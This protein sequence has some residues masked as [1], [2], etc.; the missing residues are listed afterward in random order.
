MLNIVV[1]LT[2]LLP[3]G[4]NGGAKIMALQL[5]KRMGRIAPNHQFILLANR[6]NAAE[7]SKLN[8]TNIK[9]LKI[10]ALDLTFANF[11]AG[12]VYAFFF[13]FIRFAKAFMPF[14]VAIRVER[15]AQ[16]IRQFILGKSIAK[17]TQADLFFC[18]FTAVNYKSRRIPVVAVVHDIQFHYHPYFFTREDL[19]QR[20]RNF[21][22]AYK[23]ADRIICVSEHVKNTVLDA[24][25]ISRDK[26]VSI[27]TRLGNR[28]VRAKQE[29]LV[30]T[31]KNH[32]LTDNN[33]LLYPANFWQHKN[34]QMLFTAFQYYRSKHPQSTLKLVCTGADNAHKKALADAIRQM[35]L[36]N[37]IKLPGFL[38][39]DAFSS[40]MQGCKAVIFPSLYEG[41]GMPIIEAMANSKPVLCSNLTCL[42]EIAG[43]AAILFDPRKPT[44]IANAIARLEQEPEL[45]EKLTKQ[46]SQHA[47][48]FSN[49]MDMAT[50]YLAVFHE[51][52]KMASE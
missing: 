19:F 22:S 45:I 47:L 36:D 38:A 28:L 37:W 42:P 8:T 16:I 17:R 35:G 32:E 48:K 52:V 50:E 46:G 43:N 10:S 15:L 29:T 4:E 41:F 5:I 44:D 51:V 13:P 21:A 39:D 24:A 30:S 7:L 27:Y 49:D 2:S 9:T 31:L 14:S 34:H 25:K 40:L 23:K 18:P 3:G 1:D 12:I 33:Y 6:H 26:V 20:R 11:L